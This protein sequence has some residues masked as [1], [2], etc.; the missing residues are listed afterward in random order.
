MVTK[1][2]LHYFQEE[3]D[4]DY[5]ESLRNNSW[6]MAWC[7][8]RHGICH[9]YSPNIFLLS[10]YIWS[11][12]FTNVVFF[13]KKVMEGFILNYLKFYLILKIYFLYLKNLERRSPSKSDKFSTQICRKMN[14][15][16]W[17]SLYQDKS[18][19]FGTLREKNCHKRNSFLLM[20]NHIVETNCHE[21][22]FL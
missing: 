1:K 14:N 5:L 6:M 11:V 12:G 10:L 18:Q 20:I 21:N 19:F 2:E 16:G 15:F 13:Q 22:I 9:L 8:F 7:G 4:L 17:T 3:L